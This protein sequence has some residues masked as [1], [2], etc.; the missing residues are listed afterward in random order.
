MNID[1]K[2]VYF[3][4]FIFAISITFALN[5]G[6]KSTE[7]EFGRIFFENVANWNGQ[8]PQITNDGGS[9]NTLMIVGRGTPPN[10]SV[11]V[12]DD[13]YV[14]DSLLSGDIY[15]G[16]ISENKKVCRKDQ[17]NCPECSGT[18]TRCDTSGLCS[19]IC[20]GSDC[21]NTWQQSESCGSAGVCSQLCIGN[22]CK[23]RWVNV[24]PSSFTVNCYAKA[25]Q[26]CIGGCPSGYS[27]SGWHCNGNCVSCPIGEAHAGT[28]NSCSGEG[29]CSR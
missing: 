16:S 14:G 17:T 15:Q 8:N 29:T 13:L 5:P 9:Y 12:W 4:I 10:R 25:N 24:G 11:K 19:Q 23:S 1:K 6:H 18:D 3:L 27:L 21:K 22:S 2:F 7:I 26:Y 20:I 28:Y